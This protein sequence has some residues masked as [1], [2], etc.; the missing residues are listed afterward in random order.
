[1][2][3]YSIFSWLTNFPFSR[4]YCFSGGQV[5][6][7]VL[8]SGLS[9]KL[10]RYLRI[11][12]LG[13]T[14]LNQKDAPY[15]AESKNSTSTNCIRGREDSRS[16]FRQVSET[17]HLD[18]PKI[19]EEGSLDDQT[20]EQDHDRRLARGNRGWARSKGKGRVNEGDVENEQGLISPGSGSG[21]GADGRSLKDRVINRSLEL[22]RLPDPKKGL[23]RIGG[24]SLVIEREDNDD[25]F[26]ECKVGTK[27]IS[28]LVKKAVRAAEAEA[29][30]ANAPAEA[31]KAAGDAAAEAV[32]SASLEVLS[33]SPSPSSLYYVTYL[34]LLFETYKVRMYWTHG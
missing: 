34:H 21:L 2:F 15:T 27:D 17:S 14:S 5:V 1:M 22:K 29:R 28:D 12:A 19:M 9:A 31:V 8:T 13:E 30:A 16:R 26:Q 23:G 3:F 4:I 6:E 24:D 7:D 25:C 10:M 18:A 11:R 32:K 33:L 20:A